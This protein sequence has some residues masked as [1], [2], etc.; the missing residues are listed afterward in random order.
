[1]FIICV[2]TYKD[3]D[4]MSTISILFYN[5]IIGIL[6]VDVFVVHITTHLTIYLHVDQLSTKTTSNNEFI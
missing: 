1:M 2:Y 3:S 4:G 5:G 6:V